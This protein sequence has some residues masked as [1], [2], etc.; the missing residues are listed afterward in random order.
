M[1]VMVETEARWSHCTDWLGSHN[2]QPGDER[3]T[4]HG[5]GQDTAV[6]NECGYCVWFTPDWEKWRT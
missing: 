2:A 3:W 4:D 6:C 5:N 1:D